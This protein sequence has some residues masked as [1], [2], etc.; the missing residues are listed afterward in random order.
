MS[1]KLSSRI[2][3]LLY[4]VVI[5]TAFF[6]QL[7]ML[8]LIVPGDVEKTTSAI[9]ESERSFRLA[10]LSDLVS[11]ASYMAVAVILYRAFSSAS[12]HLS[13]LALVFSLTSGAVS[14]VCVLI[15]IGPLVLETYVP[16]AS[17]SGAQQLQLLSGVFLSLGSQGTTIALV[18][19]GLHCFVVGWLII[20]SKLFPYFVGFV[21]AIGGASYVAAGS[22]SLVN[23][24]LLN[25][26]TLG[27]L[28]GFGIGDT[29]VFLWAI[30]LLCVGI[31][32]IPSSVG[33][34]NKPMHAPCETHAPDRRRSA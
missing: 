16:G 12:K 10:L 2:A 1:T 8:G 34:P 20:R 19:F 33:R 24:E 25:Q 30:W 29:V 15:R 18:F 4:L 7:V 13:L 22:L 17:E 6:S 14:V 5:G 23:P 28:P 3:G 21:L 32:P 11:L 27:H 9:I 26:F 31:Q